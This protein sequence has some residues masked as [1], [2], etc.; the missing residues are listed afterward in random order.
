LKSPHDP[1]VFGLREYQVIRV[2]NQL[3]QSAKTVSLG[4][5]MSSIFAKKF[6]RSQK[7]IVAS[8]RYERER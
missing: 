5:L 6:W 2:D 4:S 8:S 7:S 1:S 3:F